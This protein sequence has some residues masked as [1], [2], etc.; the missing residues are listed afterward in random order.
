MKTVVNCVAYRHGQRVGEVPLDDIS[1]V[2]KQADTFV[3]LGLHE[4]E[5]PVLRK[6]QEEF[7]LH[8]L[9]VEDALSAHQRP[10]VEEYGDSLFIVLHT[11]QWSNRELQLGETHIFVGHNY[12]VTIRQGASHS[13]TQVRTRVETMPQRLAGG[14]G[15]VLYAVTDFVV[16]QYRPIVDAFEQRFTQL[17]ADIFK[18]RSNRHTIAQLY[19]LKRDLM[20]LRNA[21]EPVIDIC[22]QLVR[23]HHEFVSKELR[24]YFRD[25]VDHATRVAKATDNL[26]EMVSDALQVNLALMSLRQNEVVKALASW[27]AILALP[28]MVFSMY[29]MNFQFMPEL[30]SAVGYPAA[31]LATFAGCVVLYRRFRRLGWL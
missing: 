28:T 8:E 10:K 6:I 23:L 17:E 1:E 7:D 14:P 24:E 27:G 29:G 16:D 9:A 15:F 11:A 12:V 4:P 13:Y 19:E 30:H 25:V 31:L 22:N 2:I 18:D 26:R 21:A 3:W 5:V 20:D